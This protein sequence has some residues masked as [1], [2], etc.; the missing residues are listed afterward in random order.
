MWLRRVTLTAAIVGGVVALAGCGD[1][2]DDRGGPTPAPAYSDTQAQAPEPSTTT[3]AQAAAANDGACDVAHPVRVA[4]TPAWTGALVTVCSSN[5]GSSLMLKNVSLKVLRVW[6]ATNDP[7]TRL[8]VA[9]P[10]AGTFAERAAAGVAP[11][12]CR[13]DVVN[14]R[15]PAGGTATA[16][17]GGETANVHFAVAP[18]DTVAANAARFIGGWISARLT[19][20][21]IALRQ[22]LESCARN[23]AE[24]LSG[25]AVYLDDG[26]RQMLGV[27][28]SCG[29]LIQDVLGDTES[30]TIDAAAERPNAAKQILGKAKIVLGGSFD[31]E[32]TAVALRVFRR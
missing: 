10:P 28:G 12:I 32:L 15:L 1:D 24:A 5:D 17:T 2:D 30:T 7:P 29:P 13:Q 26:I 20:R 22:R 3:T 6:A 21:G 18:E 4:P 9:D 27:Y 25:D 14:C 19:P 16:T 31:D 23:G 8:H 11:A